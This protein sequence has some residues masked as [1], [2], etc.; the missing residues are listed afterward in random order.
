MTD[1]PLALI[2]G[3]AQGIGLACAEAL[4]EDG[5]DVILSDINAEGVAAAG[6]KHTR[7]RNRRIYR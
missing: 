7:K 5:Y 4:I 3:A 6:K 2:T 1:K